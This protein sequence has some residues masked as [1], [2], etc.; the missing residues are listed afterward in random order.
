MSKK[1]LS[2]FIFEDKEAKKPKFH[3]R[4]KGITITTE[5]ELGNKDIDEIDPIE[6]IN[7][8]YENEEMIVQNSESNYRYSMNTIVDFKFYNMIQRYSKQQDL[9]YSNGELVSDEFYLT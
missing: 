6:S 4:A 9:Y 7:F 3:W 8:D 1:E 2:D 5:D